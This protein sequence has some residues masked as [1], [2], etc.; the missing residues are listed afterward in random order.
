MAIVSK[1]ISNNIYNLTGKMPV[2]P[3]GIAHNAPAIIFCFII[4]FLLY[5]PPT[6][7]V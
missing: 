7:P 3:L 1:K 2:L 5:N 4:F 6:E